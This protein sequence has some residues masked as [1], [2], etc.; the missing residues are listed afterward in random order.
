MH[1]ELQVRRGL[2]VFGLWF[3]FGNFLLG[4]ILWPSALVDPSAMH[5]VQLGGVIPVMAN[6][7]HLYAHLSTGLACLILARRSG[8]AFFGAAMLAFFYLL[9]ALLGLVS[10]HAVLGMIMVNKFGSWVHLVEGAGLLG[11]ALVSRRLP[12]PQPANRAGRR[13]VRY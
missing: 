5:A 2:T 1:R 3:V 11:V 13:S 9:I 8:S 7:W 12:R 6:G 4:S 10:D